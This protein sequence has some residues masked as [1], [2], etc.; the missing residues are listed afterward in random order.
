MNLG[1]LPGSDKKV[2]TRHKTT[3]IALEKSYQWLQKGGCLS[4]MAYQTHRGASEEVEAIKNW[5]SKTFDAKK[6]FYKG[7]NPTTSPILF[8]IC[9]S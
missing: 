8:W 6:K 5:F 3:I 2:I 4:I 9:K 1:Y 7:I